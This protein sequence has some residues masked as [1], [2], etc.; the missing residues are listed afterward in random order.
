MVQFH[1]VPAHQ[2][3]KVRRSNISLQRETNESKAEVI[4]KVKLNYGSER[5]SKS[6][7]NDSVYGFHATINEFDCG[8]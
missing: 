2:H 8:A 4:Q 6:K 7:N 5:E 3:L 1:L